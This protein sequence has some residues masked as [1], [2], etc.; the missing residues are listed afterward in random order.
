MKYL[1]DNYNLYQFIEN[2]LFKLL[3]SRPECYI[4]TW[5]LYDNRYLFVV[6]FKVVLLMRLYEKGKHTN[7][8]VKSW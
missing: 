6:S 8:R 2:Y 5:I 1:I 4:F 7:N 3:V